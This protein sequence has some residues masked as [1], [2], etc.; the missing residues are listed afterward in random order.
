MEQN[1]NISFLLAHFNLPAFLTENRIITEV[2][3]AAQ[4]HMI[5]PGTKLETMLLT[6]K[7]EYASFDKGQL[8][9]SIRLGNQEHLAVVTRTES[10]E[11]VTIMPKAN[12]PEI[13]R[14]LSLVG[15][16]IRTPLT[17]LFTLADQLLP[18]SSDQER[19]RRMV[20][21]LYQIQRIVCNMTDANFSIETNQAAC[22][23]MNVPVFFQELFDKICLNLE[24]TGS[25]LQFTNL[26]ENL[27]CL[28]NP[29]LLERGIY[30]I[31]QNAVK[32]SGRNGTIRA[33]L[34][35]KDN[36]LF[37]TVSNSLV[38][39]YVIPKAH[40]FSYFLREPGLDNQE[41]GVGLGMMIIQA[42][43]RAH[44]GTVLMQQP[45]KNEIRLTMTM[46]IRKTTRTTLREPRLRVD[47]AGEKDHCLL[48]LSDVL[49]PN[50]YDI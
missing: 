11:L 2:N 33:E 40:I 15:L 25:D 3:P 23:I 12:Q 35:Q 5:F 48:E 38:D 10:L 17:E 1:E 34:E 37:F 21:K 19:A 6:G 22:Q 32:F 16:E 45:E 39:A 24:G 46:Q 44:G 31:I 9:L 49:P 28:I 47:Y 29:E 43:A 20:Q 8:M 4:Q 42:A 30:N 26:K 14:T 50:C 13:L 36:R 41:S 27:F 7:K 18:D